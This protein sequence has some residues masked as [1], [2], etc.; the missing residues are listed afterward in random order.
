MPSI[1]ISAKYFISKLEISQHHQLIEDYQNLVM[2]YENF[3]L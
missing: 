3:L 2:L 1:R